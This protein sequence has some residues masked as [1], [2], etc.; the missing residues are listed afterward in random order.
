LPRWGAKDQVPNWIIAPWPPENLEALEWQWQEWLIPYWRDAAQFAEN[1]GIKVALEAHP[2]FCVYN[3][4]TRLRLREAT[5]PSI[6][7][8]LDPSHLYWQGMDIPIV[9]DALKDAIFHVHAKDVALNPARIARNGV[10][11][12]KSYIRMQE[13]SWLF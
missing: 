10:L 1:S 5:N 8:N 13:R 9:I 7:I 11:D 4:E 6:G 3:P 2:N 12:G